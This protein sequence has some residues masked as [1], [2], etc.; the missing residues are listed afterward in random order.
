[1]PLYGIFRF[2]VKAFLGGV[3]PQA[4]GKINFKFRDRENDKKEGMYTLPSIKKNR[5]FTNS[6][7]LLFI[8]SL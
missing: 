8:A 6:V 5:E 1:L 7:N 4:V 2:T 3:Y